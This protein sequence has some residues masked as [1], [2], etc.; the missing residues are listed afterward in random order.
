[1]AFNPGPGVGGHCIPLDPAY[2][3]W[4]SRRDTGHQF[5][6]VELAQDINDQMPAYVAPGSARPST[7]A[8][9]PSR[10][11]GCWSWA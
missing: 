7:S 9:W 1:M 3:T 2:L 8:A 6:I 11:P 5:R 4:Q 10:A